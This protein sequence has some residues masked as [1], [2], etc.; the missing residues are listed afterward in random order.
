MFFYL[1][2]LVTAL[3]LPSSVMTMLLVAGTVMLLRNRAP[4]IGR[5]LLVTGLA[6]LL[7]CG[8]S[9]LGNLLIL[10]LEQRFQ[11]PE[12]PA[13]VAGVLILGGFE[14]GIIANRRG[15]LSLN[16]AAERLTEGILVAL[17]RPGTKVVF[18]GGDAT[19]FGPKEAGAAGLVGQYLAAIGIPRERIVLEDQSRT[20]Y[21]NALFLHGMLKPRRGQRWVLVTSAFHMPRSVATFRHVGFDVVPWPA[22]YRT[23]GW[24]DATV[25]FANVPGGLERV[26]LAFKE[27][28]GLLAYRTSGRSAELWPR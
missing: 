20:T 23:R 25:F 22:D 2:K 1:S 27:W 12:L 8:Y 13:D 15:E 14:S 21:E 17:A 6:M 9:P 10:P 18:T 26:D 24:I 19:V 3:I 28:I 4:A 11:R 7:M 16:E 5:R